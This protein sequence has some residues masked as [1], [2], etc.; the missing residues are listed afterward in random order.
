MRNLLLCLLAGCSGSDDTD[1]LCDR[2]V[3]LTY[4]SF[5]QG[6]LDTHCNGCH[7]SIISPAQR[8]GAPEGVNFDTYG[9]LLQFADRLPPRVIDA[10]T[11]EDDGT[12]PMPPGG[13]PTATE[14]AMLHEWLSCE[15]AKDRDLWRE[16]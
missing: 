7:S 5:G 11:D 6:F 10:A 9:G 2:G 16:R 1:T 3:P 13:G 4:E 14:L 15:V 12:Q 8:N